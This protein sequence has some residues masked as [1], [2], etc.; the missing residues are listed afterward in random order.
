MAAANLAAPPGTT[1]VDASARPIRP[2][3]SRA[4]RSQQLSAR[5]PLFW[6]ALFFSLGVV[7]GNYAWRPSSWWFVSAA[8]CVISAGYLAKKRAVCSR[9]LIWAALIAIGALSIQMHRGSTAEPSLWL[10]DGEVQVTAHVISEGDIQSEAGSMRQRID[11]ETESID[12]DSYSKKLTEGIRLTVYQ[13][14][15][16]NSRGRMRLFSYGQRIQFPATLVPPRNY[17]NPGA[18]DY[19]G[20]LRDNGIVATAS[21]KYSAVQFL[22][23]TAGSRIE[24]WRARL[25]RSLIGKIHALWPERTAGLMDAIVLGEETFVERPTRVDFQRSG[26]Y[27]VLVVSGMNVSILAMFALWSLRRIGLGQIAASAFAVAL[28]LAYAALT[29]EGPPV[30]RAALMFAAYLCARLLYRDRAMLNALGAAALILLVI[31][32]QALLG[33]SFQMTFL[34]VALVAGI[35]VPALERT[36]QPYSRGLRNLHALAWDRVLPPK[37]A[38]FR[39]DVRLLLKRLDM[40]LPGRFPRTAALAALRTSFGFLELTAMSAILQLGLALPMAYYFHRATSLAMPANLF[41]IPFLELLMP[42]AVC[43]IGLSYVSLTV[44]SL[45]A[46]IAGFALR[47]I[48]GTVKWLGGMRLADV[49]VPTPNWSAIIFCG[50][51]IFACAIL[52]RRRPMVALGGISLLVTSALWIWLIPPN[53]NFRRNTLEMTAID[54]GQGDSILLVTPQGRKLLVDAGGLPFWTHSQLDV[55]EDVVSPYLWWRGFS[56]IDAAV[57]THAHADHM[58]GLFAIIENFRPRELWLPEGIPSAEIGRLLTEASEYR[59][60]VRYRK[61]GDIFFFGG[62]T[63]RVLAPGGESA[64]HNLRTDSHRNDESL[65]MKVSYGKTSALLEADAERPTENFVTSEDP[66]ADVLKVAHHGSASSTGSAL[67]AAVTPR[68][69]VISVGTRNVYHHP[70]PEVLQRLQAAHIVTYRTDLDG[71]TS[72]FLDGINVSAAVA[73]TR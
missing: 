73:T 55:G 17:R 39:L 65:V 3:R 64:T 54:V 47:G 49:R 15:R 29:K 38:Q 35:G 59:V 34:C 25:H 20:Y 45:P 33:A 11:I 41:V 52:V 51:A 50:V 70:R 61:A 46:A 18:F 43:A 16:D 48:A 6:A 53:Q 42:A 69:A 30:W 24:R 22:M 58:A 26:T 12:S 23:G 5:Q 13:N 37:V 67:L 44:A 56:R 27:H 68:F 19:E 36:V 66:A 31:E 2:E 14:E 40:I 57:L 63:I 9:L 8:V 21:V 10:G 62:T 4:P 32:P 1:S 60:A 71:A 72:F 7:A 28:I